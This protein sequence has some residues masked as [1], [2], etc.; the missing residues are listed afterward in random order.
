MLWYLHFWQHRYGRA[1]FSLFQYLTS[2]FFCA[3]PAFYAQ[4]AGFIA[5]LLLLS[6]ISLCINL[7]LFC[8]HFVFQAQERDGGGC[9]S[10]HP[11]LDPGPTPAATERQRLSPT[12]LPSLQAFVSRGQS[13]CPRLSPATLAPYWYVTGSPLAPSDVKSSN[14]VN[15]PVIASPA[16]G[17]AWQSTPAAGDEGR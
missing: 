15:L 7:L 9:A 17:G 1:S 5:Q 14:A 3:R 10:C 11:G 4:R 13:P 12:Q 2:L 6:A 8:T 16:S